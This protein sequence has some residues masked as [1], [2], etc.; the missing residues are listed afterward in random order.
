MLHVKCYISEMAIWTIQP[1]MNLS[2][3]PHK[4]F[5]PL[6]LTSPTPN[7][8]LHYLELQYGNVKDGNIY[9]IFWDLY[10][11]PTQEATNTLGQVLLCLSCL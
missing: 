10:R 6:E 2:L 4:V 8:W 9:E 3:C 7:Q 1:S 5:D 11:P